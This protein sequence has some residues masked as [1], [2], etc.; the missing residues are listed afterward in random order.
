MFW[1]FATRD[2]LADFLA[3]DV[4]DVTEHALVA[5][6]VPSKIVGRKSCSVI[7]W[8][9]DEMVEDAGAQRGIMLECPDGLIRLCRQ[10]R[11]TIFLTHE[12]RPIIAGNLLAIV[13][14][15]TKHLLAEVRV[16]LKE[17]ELL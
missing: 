7:R 9:R 1:C 12:L 5:K 8:Q 16:Q 13:L 3:L 4:C 14:P 10:L 11:T 6:I 17:G 15:G 2:T